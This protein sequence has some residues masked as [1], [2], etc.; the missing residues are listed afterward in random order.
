MIRAKATNRRTGRTVMFLG[1]EER[2][3]VEMRKGN[4]IHIH[5]D[6]LGFKG[7]IVI[8]LGDTADSLRE[9]F[10][11]FIGPETQIHDSR[12]EKKQ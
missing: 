7:E 4:P 1:L 2:N 10:E 5:A 8:V 6:E 9:Q 3:L 11:P 12:D